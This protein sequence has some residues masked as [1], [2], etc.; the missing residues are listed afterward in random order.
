MLKIPRKTEALI[1][2]R[3]QPGKVLLL[4]GARRTGKTF[5][6]N[7]IIKNWPGE[8]LFWNGED[9]A[10]QELLQRRSVQHYRQLVGR[11]EL[12][13]IDEAQ[14]IPDVGKILKLMVDS[15]PRLIILITGSSAFGINDRADEPLTGRKLTLQLYPPAEQELELIEDPRE[16]FDN[17]RQRLVFGNMPE[18]HTLSTPGAKTEYLRELVNDYLFKDILVFEQ[19]RKAAKLVNLVRLIAYQMGSQVSLEELGRRLSLSKNTVER[20]LDLL[21]R[22]FVVHELSGFS[23][24]L[25]KELTKS[26]KWYFVDN[27]IRNAVLSDF[28]PVEKRRDVGF[29]WE[30]YLVNERIKHQHYSGMLVNNYFWR[31]Y[32]Q[33]EIDWVEE[34]AGDLSGYEFKWQARKVKAPGAWSRAY[35]QAEYRVISP[36]N[37]GEFLGLRGWP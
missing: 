6:L 27:G 8:Y 16:R 21:E 2:T 7:E 1:K 10:V 5:L 3:L 17:L 18:V 19:V 4:S 23:R 34:Q 11:T 28:T 22:V 14:H 9:F 29:L 13:V 12:L 30:N 35:P 32:D 26:S 20:Y 33:Q 37:Y 15:F 36:G 25:R 24:N 31:T